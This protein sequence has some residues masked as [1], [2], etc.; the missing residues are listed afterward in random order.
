MKDKA[1]KARMAKTEGKRME[2]REGIKR[3]KELKELITKEEI[4]ITRVIEEK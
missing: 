3:K 4:E 2:E 1:N